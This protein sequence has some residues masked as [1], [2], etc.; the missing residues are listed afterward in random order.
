MIKWSGQTTLY[1]HLW[2]KQGDPLPE[3][4]ADANQCIKKIW[5]LDAQWSTCPIEVEEQVKDLWRVYEL[6]NDHY[7]FKTSIEELIEIEGNENE[8]ER[9]SN[10]LIQ[11]VKV[12]LKT[13]AI[14]QYMREQGISDKDQ[15]IIHWWW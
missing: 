11:W 7:M 13:D 4:P 9:F 8:V 12:P 6:G 3:V 15:V 2:T 14:V 5:F 10:E 1:D